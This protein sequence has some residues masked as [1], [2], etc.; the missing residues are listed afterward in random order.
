MT[1]Q[2]SSSSCYVCGSALRPLEEAYRCI[3]CGVVRTT[4]SYNV[5][6]YAEGYAKNY[7][8]YSATDVNTPLNLFRLGLVSRWLKQRDR[9]LDVGCCVGEFLRFA[10]HWYETV[11]FEPNKVAAT[12]ARKRCDSK[13]MT[14][15]NGSI[16]QVHCVTLFDVLEHMEDP[17]GFLAY[18][19]KEHLFPGGVI[20][21]TTP[22]VEVIPA[23]NEEALRAWK[24]WKPTEHLFLFTE[25]GLSRIASSLNLEVLHVGHEE[26]D[27]RPGNP[28]GDIL[29]F[30][31]R[32]P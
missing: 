8:R 5:K 21:I 19:C 1:I 24:H 25:E 6:M 15:L 4:H 22:N 10:E 13:I 20:V 17:R 23:W 3:S 2:I 16:G 14:E 28:N 29:T 11:G 26:S 27:I 32:R 18:L 9:I 7:V 30:V 12:M 31:V